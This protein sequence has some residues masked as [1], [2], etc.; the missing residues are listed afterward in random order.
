MKTLDRHFAE[1]ESHVFGFGYGTGEPHI[2]ASL[3]TFMEA[4]EIDG[5]SAKYDYR[6][7]EETLT[8]PVAWL[9][10]NI[11]GHHDIIEYGTSPRFAWLTGHGRALRDFV[12]SKSLDELIACTEIDDLDHCTPTFCNCGPEG[13]SA[14]KLCFNPFWKAKQGETG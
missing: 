10:I 4:I 1:W 13:Y 5:A 14:K 2:L 6:K 8:P 11:F 7:L 9:L 12:V 3:K